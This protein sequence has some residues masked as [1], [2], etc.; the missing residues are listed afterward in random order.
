MALAKGRSRVLSGP[1]TLHTQT[2]IEIAKMLTK[3]S[4]SL[5]KVTELL[6]VKRVVNIKLSKFISLRISTNVDVKAVRCII[7]NMINQCAVNLKHI[8]LTY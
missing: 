7:F 1:I 6:F 8:Y 3:V 4:L 5:F 2:A